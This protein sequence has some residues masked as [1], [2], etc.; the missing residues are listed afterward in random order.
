M[1]IK[2]CQ[3]CTGVN[4]NGQRCKRNTCRTDLCFQHLRIIEGLKIKPS[5]I[6]GADLGLWAARDF[7]IRSNIVRYTGE[8]SLVPIHGNYVLEINNNL[9]IDAKNTNSAAGRYINDC[10]TPDIRMGNCRSNNA[11]FS[12]DYHNRKANIKASRNIPNGAEIYIPY[13]RNYWN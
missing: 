7:A 13:S 3:R 1:S 8:E 6:T 2:V 5:N 4:R 9:F 11:K 10:R 12:Y